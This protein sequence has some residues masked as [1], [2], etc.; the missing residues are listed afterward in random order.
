MP[1][2]KLEELIDAVGRLEELGDVNQLSLPRRENDLRGFD[3]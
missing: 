1:E 3:Q 2:V